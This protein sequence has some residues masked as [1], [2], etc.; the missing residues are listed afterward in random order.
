MFKY[1]LHFSPSTLQ[2]QRRSENPSLT[3]L[4]LWGAPFHRNEKQSVSVCFKSR[5][6]CYFNTLVCNFDVNTM[7]S[8]SE[9]CRVTRVCAIGHHYDF[10]S[11]SDGYLRHMNII[12]GWG[13]NPPSPQKK[14]ITLF[15][16]FLWFG[17]IQSEK[18]CPICLILHEKTFGNQQFSRGLAPR[19]LYS[20]IF[21]FVTFWPP[22]PHWKARCAP[23]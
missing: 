13:C 9:T 11:F 7:C 21:L 6:Q 20:K 8:C 12:G 16:G 18:Q 15:R 4:C 10:C 2:K 17:D 1:I 23:A 22:P 3:V 5:L 19:S 14:I